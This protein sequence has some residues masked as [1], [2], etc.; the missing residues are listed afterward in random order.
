MKKSPDSASSPRARPAGPN[1]IENHAMHQ[2]PGRIAVPVEKST[3]HCPMVQKNV[4][5]RP[6]QRPKQA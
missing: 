6:L 5:R 1:E 3:V 2:D 4:V